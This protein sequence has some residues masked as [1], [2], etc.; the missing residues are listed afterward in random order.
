MVN[1]LVP[2]LMALA[3]IFGI[4]LVIRSIILWYYCINERIANQRKI[5][6]ILQRIEEN[7]QRIV[8]DIE[9]ESEKTTDKPSIN[10][11]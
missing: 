9:E 7:T 4:F 2:L 3:L 11:Y 6:E 1:V 8:D 5:I 10:E